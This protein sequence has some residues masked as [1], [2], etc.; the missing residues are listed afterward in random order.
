MAIKS[1]TSF[2]QFFSLLFLVM[3]VSVGVALASGKNAVFTLPKAASVNLCSQRTN[4][5]PFCNNR[6]IYKCVSGVAV[7]VKNCSAIGGWCDGLGIGDVTGC[8]DNSGNPISTP[9]PKSP[10]VPTKAPKI[11][12]GCGS[13]NAGACSSGTCGLGKK[14]AKSGK[15]CGCVKI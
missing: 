14:C 1:K 15:S 3:A 2:I 10:P 4:N 5:V 9:K 11:E 6:I 12:S 7:L 8:T 13:A